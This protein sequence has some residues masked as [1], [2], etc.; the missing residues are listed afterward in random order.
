M[1][2]AST[3]TYFPNLLY[4]TIIN[5]FNVFCSEIDHCLADSFIDSLDNRYCFKISKKVSFK[6][7]INTL[8]V[9]LLHLSHG[10]DKVFNWM[11]KDYLI[12]RFNREENGKMH[13]HHC[14]GFSGKGYINYFKIVLMK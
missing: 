10:N 9:I 14:L 4:D 8:P 3:D 13:M 6:R 2:T 12:E 7:F 1:D 5:S 11:P